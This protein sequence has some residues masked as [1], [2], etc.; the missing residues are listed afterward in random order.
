MGFLRK[1]ETLGKLLPFRADDVVVK[2]D[3]VLPAAPQYLMHFSISLFAVPGLGVVC[4][5]DS[6]LPACSS[7]LYSSQ[8]SYTLL[9]HPTLYSSQDCVSYCFTAFMSILF[10]QFPREYEAFAEHNGMISGN[11]NL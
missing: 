6:T 8:A 11:N 4:G 5:R 1:P 10:A 9:N 2:Q 3:Q 7:H